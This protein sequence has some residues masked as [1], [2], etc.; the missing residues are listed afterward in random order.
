[1]LVALVALVAACSSA[2]AAS[3]APSPSASTSTRPARLP[4]CA[5]YTPTTQTGQ[6]VIVAVTGPACLT[7][8]LIA[9]IADK[10][11]KPWAST[12]LRIGTST[13]TEFAQALKGGTTVQIFED[14]T[15]L[16]TQATGGYLA[17]DLS[18]AGWIV[19]PPTAPPPRS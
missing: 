7:H 17:D 8:A 15:A 13:G 18:A 14:G 11:G 10:S 4:S 5:W 16:A 9:W 19:E 2:P 6:Q 1:V 12:T 3:P